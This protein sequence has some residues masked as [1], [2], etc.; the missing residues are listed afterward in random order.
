VDVDADLIGALCIERL[1]Y[2]RKECDCIAMA[3]E[4]DVPFNDF[5]KFFSAADCP[6]C[7]VCDVQLIKK[8]DWF[9]VVECKKCGLYYFSPRM[10]E[11]GQKARLDNYNETMTTVNASPSDTAVSSEEYEF[12]SK[13]IGSKKLRMLDVG[14]LTV[15]L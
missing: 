12:L 3:I 7:R 15:P 5:K 10:N 1:I 11:S 6:Y 9:S 4:T 8:H 14:A 13:W 2:K